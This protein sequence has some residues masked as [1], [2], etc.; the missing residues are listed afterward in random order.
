MNYHVATNGCNISVY[1]QTINYCV[2]VDLVMGAMV[3]EKSDERLLTV[4]RDDGCRA[5][6]PASSPFVNCCR[7]VTEIN[8]A[9]SVHMHPRNMFPGKCNNRV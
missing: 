1:N 7:V 5:S 4:M 3:R 2:V 9:R 8:S 6:M